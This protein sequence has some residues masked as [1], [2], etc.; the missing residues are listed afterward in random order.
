MYLGIDFGTTFSQIATIYLEQPTL[1]LNR[2]EYGIPSEFYYDNEWG[3][4]VGQEAKDAGQGIAA[5]NLVSEVKMAILSGKTFVLDGRTFTAKDIVKEIYKTLIL[6]AIQVAK[7][8][9]LNIEIEGVVLT[10]P[11]KFGIQEKNL[12]YEAASE[13]LEGTDIKVK[14]IIKEPVAAAISYY[15]DITLMNNKNILVYDLGGGTCDIALVRADLSSADQFTVI[16]SD[17]VRIGGRDWDSELINYIVSVIEYRYQ[18]KINENAGYLEK[19]RRAAVS[20]KH[21]LSNP[22]KEKAAARVELNGMVYSIIISRRTFDEITSHLLQQTFDCLLDMYD[23]YYKTCNIDEV[24]CVGGSSNMCQ[25]EEGLIKLFKDT[26]IKI[27]KFDPELAVVSGAAIYANTETKLN[28]IASLS[29]GTDSNTH[30]GYPDNKEVLSIILKKGAKLPTTNSRNYCTV[31]DNQKTVAF[32]IYES[33][34]VEDVELS[35]PDKRFIG[36]VRLEL[37]PNTPIDSSLKCALSLNSN[38]LLDVEASGPLGKKVN[39]TFRI[40][41]I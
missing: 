41:Q 4:L 21:E 27:R 11:V 1:L 37:P 19:I 20:V 23:Q 39:A 24:I 30:Y 26:D 13:C 8:K 6:K 17:M 18:I 3:I 16:A 22:E 31:Y 2:G 9:N 10:I 28:D 36:V 5:K 38:G 34:Y 29:Y 35:V 32:N 40:N 25:V 33:E 15:N 14:A 12:I 7:S